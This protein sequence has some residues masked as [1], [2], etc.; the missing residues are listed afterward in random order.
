MCASWI[1]AGAELA[2]A[3]IDALTDMLQRRAT[4]GSGGPQ[5]HGNPVKPREG[6][7]KPPGT[8]VSGDRSIPVTME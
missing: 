3:D 7:V 2:D 6:A 4:S 8:R 1:L 5:H